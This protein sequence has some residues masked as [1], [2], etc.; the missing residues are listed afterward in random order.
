MQRSGN[1]LGL[2]LLLLMTCSGLWSQ[3]LT[4]DMKLLR[5]HSFIRPEFA[6]QKASFMFLSSQS[7]V[8]KYNPVSLGFGALM[9]AY[10]TVLSRQ[11]SASCLYSPSCSNYSRHLISDYG[12][13][14]GIIFS[15]DRIMRC[16]RIALID[17]PVSDFD[18]KDHKVHETTS[19]YKNR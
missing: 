7:P 3:N 5:D 11:I 6:T 12:L 2:V 10:Q 14:R 19:I 4:E 13:I 1:K 17:I 8:L 18:E 15:S 16:N 9:Y